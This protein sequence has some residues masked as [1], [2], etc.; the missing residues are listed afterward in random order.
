MD[1]SVQMQEFPVEENTNRN[2]TLAIRSSKHPPSGKGL[3]QTLKP[4]KVE[5]K[6][7]VL[8]SKKKK[9]QAM[10]PS[11]SPQPY[12]DV[13]R[14]RNEFAELL[15]SSD[16]EGMRLRLLGSWL[17]MCLV[18]IGHSSPLDRSIASLVAGHKA[19]Y[20]ADQT[21]AYSARVR[22]CEALRCV[23]DVVARGAESVTAEIIAATKMLMLYE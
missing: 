13:E 21:P 6:R 12:C 10:T 18:R 15:Y 14:L 11:I 2:V 5:T 1:L 17:D 8:T 19:R 20:G 16:S 7:K 9:E 3:Y 22:Y 23:N 4:K